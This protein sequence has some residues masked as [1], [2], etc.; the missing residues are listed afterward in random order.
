MK[1]ASRL[2]PVFEVR[3]GDLSAE[4]RFNIMPRSRMPR[5]VEARTTAA[6]ECGSLKRG[7]PVVDVIDLLED[8]DKPSPNGL[9]R[10]KKMDVQD[11][12]EKVKEVRAKQLRQMRQMREEREKE[13]KQ[14]RE[15]R[16]KEKLKELLG[17]K[18]NRWNICDDC[19]SVPFPSDA[20]MFCLKCKSDFRAWYEFCNEFSALE[21][22][23]KIWEE[24][25][26]E[27]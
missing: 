2:C 13:E 17:V 22:N 6:P 12:K 16:K 5:E 15:D 14:L 1:F 24:C 20:T 10:R 4:T 18:P 26:P 8:E 21:R 9:R 19:Y 3:F 25:F 7:R 11:K 23:S 27:D